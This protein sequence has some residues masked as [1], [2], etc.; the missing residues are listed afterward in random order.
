M[1]IMLLVVP[2]SVAAAT[3]PVNAQSYPNRPI[4]VVV[5][6]TAGSASDLLARMIA[7]K[8]LDAW[9]QQVV[10]D[11]RPGAGSTIGTQLVAA[12]TPDGHTFLLNSSAFAGAASIYPKLPY[13]TYKD[14]TPVTLVAGN[15]LVMVVS[16][17][18]GVKSVKDLIALARSQPGKVTYGSSGIGS[19]THFGAELFAYTAKITVVH[20]PYK[21][22]P[23]QVTD[24]ISAR[25]HYS[26]PPILAAAPLVRDGKLL[27]IG[28]TSRERAPMLP[29]IPTVAEAGVPGYE[30]D[31]W[32]GIIAPAKTPAPIIDKL[33]REIVRIVE[34]PDY[35]DRVAAMGG[36][37]RHC[38]PEEFSQLIR[39][40]IETRSR[41]FKAAGAKVG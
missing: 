7:P 10:V 3:L 15:P 2:L 18:L 32:F 11:N 28:V 4:R 26:V 6:F 24:T 38:T 40:E 1:R 41:V 30:Y 23:E 9:G 21:G 31:G 14:F 39:K 12:A 33:G 5:P 37:A 17:S 36:S 34:S 20:V 16:P 27:A 13:D 35:K 8:L 19:G 25:I 22:V 29:D